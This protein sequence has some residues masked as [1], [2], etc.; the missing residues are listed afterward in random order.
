MTELWLKNVCPNMGMRVLPI[1]AIPLSNINILND[2]KVIWFVPVNNII[3][4]LPHLLTISQFV[5]FESAC[6]TI[7]SVITFAFLIFFHEIYRINVELN[8]SLILLLEFCILRKIWLPIFS[9]DKNRKFRYG[10]EISF[11]IDSEN[12]MKKN[13]ECK[14]YANSADIKS[15]TETWPPP[16]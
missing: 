8:L 14:S 5:D 16:Q 2:T 10:V 13:R 4:S 3:C 12:F 15:L 9:W 6:F 11:F 7:N 1:W